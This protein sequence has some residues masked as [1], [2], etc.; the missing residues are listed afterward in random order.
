MSTYLVGVFVLLKAYILL[1][2][3]ILKSLCSC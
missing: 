3:D 1:K 2:L